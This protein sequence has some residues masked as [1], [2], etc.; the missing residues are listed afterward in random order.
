MSDRVGNPKDRFS[1]KAAY[2]TSNEGHLRM[3]LMNIQEHEF[4][5]QQMK[6]RSNF[7]RHF[8]VDLELR[9]LMFDD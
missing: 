1:G 8:L 7:G 6:V 4:C 3:T 9:N 2:W 5:I